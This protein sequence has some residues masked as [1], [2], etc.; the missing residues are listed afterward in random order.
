MVD[1][2]GSERTER[3]ARMMDWISKSP[4]PPPRRVVSSLSDAGE[5]LS[6]IK[7]CASAASEGKESVDQ[8]CREE[9]LLQ[10]TD[11]GR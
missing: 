4:E 1:G 9:W 2:G 8:L 3:L 11:A 6:K 10:E 7:R 5:L